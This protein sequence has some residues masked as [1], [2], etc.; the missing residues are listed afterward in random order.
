MELGRPPRTC[1]F[2]LFAPD[3]IL[4][5]HLGIPWDYGALLSTF[6]VGAPSA[7]TPCNNSEHFSCF[8]DTQEPAD[9]DANANV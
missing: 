4:P 6:V 2:L 3:W 7:V 8:F 5:D 9:V 1:F